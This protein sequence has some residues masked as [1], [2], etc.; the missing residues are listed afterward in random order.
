MRYR[1]YLIFVLA[2]VSLSMARPASAGTRDRSE[3]AK[4]S[5]SGKPEN[6]ALGKKV[7]S[8]VPESPGHSR[9]ADRMT[10]GNKDT[11]AYPGSFSLCY[12]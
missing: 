2:S 6:I 1:G 10:D 7:K 4:P 9:S 3:G 11:D 5:P 8:L 12:G